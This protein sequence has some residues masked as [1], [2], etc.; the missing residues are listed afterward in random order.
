MDIKQ[1]LKLI[2]TTG[3]ISEEG[4]KTLT[5]LR[6]DLEQGFLK[7]QWGRPKYLME[8]A[9][10]KDMKFPTPD[11]KYW[12]STLERDIQFQNLVNLSYDY[13]EKLADIEIKEAEKE[14]LEEDTSRVA[15]AKSKKL[16]IQIEREKT[17]LAYMGKQASE[18]LREIVDWT[19]LIKEVEPQLKYSKD[20]PEEHMPEAFLLRFAEQKQIIDKIGATDMNGAMNLIGLGKSA[21]KYWQQRNGEKVEL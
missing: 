11:A 18:M 19:G 6:A 7:R 1:N 12:Q 3:A 14:E 13:K 4:S 20:N 17:N 9:V 16:A 8:V 10:L 21:S 5:N 2:K 15:R